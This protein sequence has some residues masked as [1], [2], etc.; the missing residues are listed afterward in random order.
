MLSLLEG[1]LCKPEDPGLTQN[2]C[3][4]DGLVVPAVIQY[5]GGRD[6]RVP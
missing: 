2:L 5:W 4:T 6:R 1:L 3:E